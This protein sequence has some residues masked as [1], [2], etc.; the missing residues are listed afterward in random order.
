MQPI[1]KPISMQ[2]Y[3]QMV[4]KGFDQEQVWQYE[5]AMY[6]LATQLYTLVNEYE[7][8]HKSYGVKPHIAIEVR[9]CHDAFKTYIQ[10]MTRRIADDQT[11]N[12]FND[13]QE[14][15]QIVRKFAALK[16]LVNYDKRNPTK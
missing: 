3:Q 6:M 2:L 12:F 8:Y 15:D 4:A 1:K 13:C 16:D 10:T 11:I 5:G 9:R 14:F 7:E